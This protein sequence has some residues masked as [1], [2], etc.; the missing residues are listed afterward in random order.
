MYSIKFWLLFFLSLWLFSCSD[1][2]STRYKDTS[3]LEIPPKME[4]VEKPKKFIAESNKKN[5]L[6]LGKQVIL[7]GSGESSVIKVK[8]MFDR[9]W[10]LVEQSLK[11]SKI[12]ITDKNRDKGVFYV[13]FDPDT[14][15]SGD[16]ELIDTLTFYIFE[17][18]YEEAIY[19]LT[20]NWRE[21]DTEI[22]AEL[23]NDFTSDLLDDDEDMDDESVDS[24]AKL[25]STLYKVIR[26]DLPL[27]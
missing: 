24:G 7:S 17:D 14:Q 19:K 25:L 27:N 5:E 6:G 16:S 12:E 10:E 26:D 23:A 18:K 11:L 2:K 8:K 22:S 9:S 20:V 1:V 4:I 21:S 13:K 3:H 15:D